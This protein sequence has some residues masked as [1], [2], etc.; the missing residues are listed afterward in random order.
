MIKTKRVRW[1]G[2]KEMRNVYKMLV[3]KPEGKKPFGRTRRRWKGDF[4]ETALKRMNLIHLDHDRDSE[5]LL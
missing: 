5:T 3:G 1:T 4:R 2:T